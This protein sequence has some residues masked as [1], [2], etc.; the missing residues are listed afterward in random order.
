[1]SGPTRVRKALACHAAVLA[2][3]ALLT[4]ACTTPFHISS[5]HVT[6]AG[7]QPG[8]DVKALTCQPVTTL[9]IAAPAGIQG[10]GATAAHALITAF[11]KTSPP[12]RAVAVPE[13]VSRLADHDLTE[14]Y[15]ELLAGYA[16][17]GIMERHRLGRIADALGSRYVIQAGLA[18]FNQ[19]VLD[20]FEFWGLKIVRTH[21]M[22]LRLWLQVW[23]APT[24]HLLR[25]TT[26]ELSATTPVVREDSAMTFDEIAQQLWAR[27]LEKDLL[28]GLAVDGACS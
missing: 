19:G 27:M 9:G 23:D 14:A 24:G 1:M 7:R 8:L 12:I 18:A 5:Q 15:G 6:S 20:R 26:G 28:E 4:A 2:V 25:E 16:R 22:S 3:P 17:T 13:T 10:L 11:S 21:T